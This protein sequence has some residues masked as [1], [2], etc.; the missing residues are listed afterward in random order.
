[1]EL[2]DEHSEV[3]VLK[4]Q[5]RVNKD[6]NTGGWL[7]F[8]AHIIDQNLTLYSDWNTLL[9]QNNQKIY[10]KSPGESQFNSH[11]PFLP[12]IHW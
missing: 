10:V 6:V 9:D 1:M 7:L 8:S 12:P 11:S 5:E 2:F 3:S 4:L